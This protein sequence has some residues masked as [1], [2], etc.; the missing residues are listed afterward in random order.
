MAKRQVKLDDEELEKDDAESQEKPKRK[1]APKKRKAVVAAAKPKKEEAP[2][3]A[4]SDRP[5]SVG[6]IIIKTA[7]ERQSWEKDA[8]WHRKNNSESRFRDHAPDRRTKD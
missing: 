5:M 4:K 2:K 6:G 7:A 8:P 1:Q 3:K